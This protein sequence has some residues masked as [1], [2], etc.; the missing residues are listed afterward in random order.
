MLCLTINKQHS[1]RCLRLVSGDNRG[2]GSN[3]ELDQHCLM[4][5]S[6]VTSKPWHST[7]AAL[8]RHYQEQCALC[9]IQ[10]P[11]AWL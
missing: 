10:Q 2:Q 11:A 9:A 5:F 8:E 1:N 7:H 4:A 6:I 3:I